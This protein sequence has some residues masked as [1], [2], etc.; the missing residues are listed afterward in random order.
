LNKKKPVCRVK[1]Q[2]DFK[3]RRVEQGGSAKGRG[4][5]PHSKIWKNRMNF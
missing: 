5:C 4:K 1:N 2:V 3:V